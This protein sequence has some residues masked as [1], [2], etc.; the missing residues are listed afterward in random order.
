MRDGTFEESG[1]LAGVALNDDG[2]EPGGMG[3][4][5]ADLDEDGDQP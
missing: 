1:L 4:A 2:Q 3:V 5:V